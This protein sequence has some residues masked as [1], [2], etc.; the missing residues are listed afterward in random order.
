MVSYRDNST[1]QRVGAASHSEG[2][3]PLPPSDQRKGSVDSLGQQLS[4]CLPVESRG[5]SLTADVSPNMGNPLGVSAAGYQP[6][7]EAHPRESECS[8]RWPVEKTSDYRHGMVSAPQRSTPDVL[9]LVHH[10]N[11][12]VCNSSQ[13]QT[14]RVC[15][16]SARPSSSSSGCF[17][18]SLG[19]ALGICL[20]SNCAD[21]TSASQVDA[22]GGSTSTLPAVASNAPRAACGL[23]TEGAAISATP[24]TT[25]V[26]SV[27]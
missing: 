15:G 27:P 8:S 19:P 21:A 2:C 24:E 13:Q 10:L 16:S 7:S 4:S 14:G 6:V 17:V 18:N 3:P 1:H 23:S 25:S 22:A 12:P 20:S 9:H 26:R 5:H 11:G